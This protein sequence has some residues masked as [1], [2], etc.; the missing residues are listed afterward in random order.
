MSSG[1]S[2]VW[3]AC[4]APSAP[5][6]NVT[7]WRRRKT[8]MA[9]IKV[10]DFCLAPPHQ[11][12][13]YINTA[14]SCD[15]G[16]DAPA[17]SIRVLWQTV[18]LWHNTT[19][20]HWDSYPGVPLPR[21]TSINFKGGASSYAFYNTESSETW[22]EHEKSVPF[23]FLIWSQGAWHKGQLLK[24]GVPEKSLENRCD[25]RKT[26]A[27]L[28]CQTWFFS[29]YKK[30]YVSPCCCVTGKRILVWIWF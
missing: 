30:G 8:C 18:V 24:G 4:H 15:A 25:R 6:G 22:N 1:A 20:R 11:Q 5:L 12:R 9:K 26:L 29:R 17:S 3:Q 27:C 19:V 28:I 13:N 10:C 2:R 16:R 14:P 21:G 7:N 23:N